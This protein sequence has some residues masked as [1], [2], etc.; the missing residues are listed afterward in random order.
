MSDVN[1]K[2]RTN[3]VSKQTEESS[4]AFRHFLHTRNLE[5]WCT[6]KTWERGFK[7]FRVFKYQNQKKKSSRGDEVH[8]KRGIKFSVLKAK[9]SA[10]PRERGYL[11]HV[12]H[13]F[14]RT[15]QCLVWS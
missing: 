9:S 15:V 8:E 12:A 11:S 5:R 10:P 4:A 3:P 2:G 14:T 6:N 7:T 1:V 13:Q